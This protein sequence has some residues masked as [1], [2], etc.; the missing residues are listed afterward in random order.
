MEAERIKKLAGWSKG[1]QKH[2][3]TDR[4]KNNI[5]AEQKL[6]ESGDTGKQKPETDFFTILMLFSGPARDVDSVVVVA[7]V[8]TEK[9]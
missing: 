6:G 8:D 4:S 3:G 2:G 1:K 5:K 7:V 9:R